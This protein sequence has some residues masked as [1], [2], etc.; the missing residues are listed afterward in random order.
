[1]A[2]KGHGDTSGLHGCLVVPQLVNSLLLQEQSLLGGQKTSFQGS[3]LSISLTC[4]LPSHH[5]SLLNPFLP[6]TRYHPCTSS[7][8]HLIPPS[9]FSHPLIHPLFLPPQGP[10]KGGAMTPVRG[11]SLRKLR[12]KQSSSQ[13]LALLVMVW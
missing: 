4:P 1:M 7:L 12:R 8:H 6:S 5:H 10:D 11:P 13:D 2:T 9:S 3:F